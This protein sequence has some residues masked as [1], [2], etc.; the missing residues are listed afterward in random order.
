MVPPL[1]LA[2][3]RRRRRTRTEVEP[4]ADGLAIRQ[5]TNTRAKG[6]WDVT[7]ARLVLA[8]LPL[9]AARAPRGVGQRWGARSVRKSMLLSLT[10][11][12]QLLKQRARLID[13]EFAA[14]TL[15]SIRLRTH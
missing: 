10:D 12:L 11:F 1:A 9:P 2:T 15:I 4:E 3:G 8:L 5:P 7:R 13:I 14:E 6:T